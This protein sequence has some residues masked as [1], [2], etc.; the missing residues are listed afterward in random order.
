MARP[1]VFIASSSEGLEITKTVRR[2]LLQE[3]GE[4]AVVEPWTRAFELSS[5]Y[6]ESLE[7]AV[8]ESDFA[9]L[10]LTPDDVTTSR[11]K[12]KLAPRDN[13]VFELGLFM[14]RLGRERSYI[15]QE[16][17]LDL[18]LP[19]DL[20][21]VKTAA[22]KR[23]EDGD[24]KAALDPVCAEIGERILALGARFKLSSDASAALMETR[25]FSTLVEGAWWSR[26]MQNDIVSL[27]FLEIAEPG[28][29]AA[30]PRRQGFANGG[31]YRHRD[32]LLE[33]RREG[34]RHLRRPAAFR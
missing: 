20:L 5:T 16:D 8:E 11:K 27:G 15:I 12:E 33:P 24:W 18:K 1:K 34:T 19:T 7:K 31:H 10:V 22:F 2:L 17:R 14:G 30:Q 4:G 23:P 29:A 3:L 26:I 9:I 21:G 32:R 28:A 13:V 6:I 25:E